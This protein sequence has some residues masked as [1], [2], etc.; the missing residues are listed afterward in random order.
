MTPRSTNTV[1]KQLLK[2]YD[3]SSKHPETAS[4]VSPAFV[5]LCMHD[6]DASHSNHKVVPSIII[7]QQ[8]HADL[9]KL[10]LPTTELCL[11]YEAGSAQPAC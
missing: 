6:N 11:G 3:F 4:K 9:A 7:C 10:W 2:F 5:L 8:P 1:A